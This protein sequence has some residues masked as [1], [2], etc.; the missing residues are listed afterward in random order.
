MT[1][2]YNNRKWNLPGFLS[3]STLGL[4]CLLMLV[5][6]STFFAAIGSRK[7][8][9]ADSSFS[10][11]AAG[12]YGQTSSTTANLNY[13]A[14][15]GASFNL[16]LGDLNYDPATV[17]AD[18]WSSYV[19][20][21]LPA[22]FP[23]EI[24]VGEHDT[25]QIDALA[26][27]LPDQ[28]GTIS[29]TYAKEYY[30][31]YPPGNPL[32]RFIMV[33]PGGL[34]SGYQYTQGSPHYK[35]VAS[36]IDNARAANIPWVI[37]GMHKYCI[38]VRSDH[39]DACAGQ[40]LLNLLIGKKVDLI[41][42]GQ[43]HGYQASKQ[44]TLNGTTCASLAV[45][46]YNA[47]CVVDDTTSLTKGA[48]SV[49]DITGTGG[50]SLATIDTSDPQAGYF[51]T[52]MGGDVNPT[53]GVSRFTVSATRLTAQFVPV[54]G[55]TFSDGFTITS[56]VPTPT[57]SPT[58]TGTS[59]PTPTPTGT[60]IPTSSG[61]V[62]PT[63]Y[64][65][66]GKVGQGF[67]EFL[68]IQNPDRA[69][70][71]SVS[72]QYLLSSSTTVPKIIAVPPNTRWT[73]GVNNDLNTAASSTAYQ[74]VSTVVN[75]TNTSACKGVVVERPIYFTNFKGISSGTDA[76][77]A[78]HLSTD[79]YFADVSSL[80][81]Y[82]SYITILNP[83]SG[84]AATITV[85]YYFASSIQGTDTLVVQPGT[86]G[87]IIPKSLNAR[88]AT[89]VHSDQPVVVER[90]TYF[91]NY[92]YGNAQNAYGSATVV[93]A[94][95]P[96]NDWRFAEG[97]TGGQFQ[98]NLVL[99]NFGTTLANATVVLEY[100]NGSTLTNTYPI[101]PQ[102]NITLDVNFATDRTIGVCSPKPCALSQSVSAEITTN[103]G[104]NI[105]AEREMFFH[106]N[107][108]DRALN[109]TTTAMGGTDDVGQSGAATNTSYSFAEGYTFNGYD[110]WL[111]AQNPTNNLETVW[112][113]LINGKGTVY[114]F[115]IS[116]LAHSRYTLNVDEKVV[117]QM[118]HTGDGTAGY[119]VSMTV[120]TTDGSAFVAER[121][122]YW[123]VGGSQG[124][125]DVIGYLGG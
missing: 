14:G 71:C 92:S 86:R 36:T 124:G 19:K 10:F 91:N 96:A 46:S 67:T 16:A 13:I 32:A 21:H 89:W 88:A 37:V 80:P 6:A 12:D 53:W 63:W 49:I 109:R 26:A 125:D 42:Q 58:P 11:T 4:V 52:W 69:N 113:T 101:N 116:V 30:F 23:F 76:L 123:N 41:L 8:A 103:P 114:S 62:S 47:S 107:H 122:M 33:S 104:T 64:F 100:D 57:P 51:R 9:Q 2:V 43:K 1:T 112:V 102:D 68:T 97:Y 77:G 74:A 40:D 117:L 105:V 99:A 110:E 28:V 27:D 50:K 15:S 56:S 34:V 118:Y 65:A 72:I 78:T 98:E 94:P 120:Q 70:S 121:P 44:L 7:G 60:P 87:T 66:E 75:V 29:G 38:V 106:F 61:P 55:G 22:N 5:A 83:P 31:D 39:L 59:T 17:S 3:L 81:G 90:P 54:S 24:V 35:W 82:H 93:G 20:G 84:T 79:F 108:F 95:K 18:V 111:T 25:A 48:G 73:E 85:T 45:G 115:S 119:Q